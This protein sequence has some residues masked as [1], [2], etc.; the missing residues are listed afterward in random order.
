MLQPTVLCCNLS[1]DSLVR[2]RNI[3]QSLQIAVRPVTPLEYHLPVGALAGIPIKKASEEGDALS[4][5]ESM[6]VMCHMLS[7]QLDAFLQSL[8][9]S[10]IPP[11]AL[12]AVLTPSNVT[13]TFRTLYAELLGEHEAI[14]RSQM[15]K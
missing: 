3:C 12:K 11:I 10:G 2:L 1:G 13:W 4:M 14:L 6:L 15:K 9:V 8:R 7:P 5:S